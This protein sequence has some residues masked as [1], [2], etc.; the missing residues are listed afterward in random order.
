LYTFLYTL[1]LKL[2]TNIISSQINFY[3]FC[4]AVFKSLKNCD[5]LV[6]CK[7]SV[8]LPYLI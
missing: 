3:L 2:L 7:G 1:F 4:R 5:C 6:K 8:N